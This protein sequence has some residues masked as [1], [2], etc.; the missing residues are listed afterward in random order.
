MAREIDDLEAK[1]GKK[2]VSKEIRSDI[3]MLTK[4]RETIVVN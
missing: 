4:K 2:E 3:D 1:E